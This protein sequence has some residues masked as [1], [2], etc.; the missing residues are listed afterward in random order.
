MKTQMSNGPDDLNDGGLGD[1]DKMLS[2]NFICGQ[3]QWLS[4]D[5]VLFNVKKGIKRAKQW[6]LV[7]RGFGIRGIFLGRNPLE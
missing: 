1:I 2:K 3:Y 6:S 7:I 5:F 4:T